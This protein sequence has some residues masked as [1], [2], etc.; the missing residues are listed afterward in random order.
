MVGGTDGADVSQM[1]GVIDAIHARVLALEQKEQDHTNVVH[2][3]IDKWSKEVNEM[4]KKLN[5]KYEEGEARGGNTQNIRKMKD[6]SGLKFKSEKRDEET[7]SSWSFEFEAHMGRMFRGAGEQFLTWA[8]EEETEIKQHHADRKAA[9]LGMKSDVNDILYDELRKTCN[10]GE[11]QLIL[12]KLKSERNGAE[13]WR[14]MTNRYDPRGPMVAQGILEKLNTIEWPKDVNEVQN[15]IGKMDVMIKEYEQITKE[16]YPE[17]AKR[18]RLV[19]ILPGDYKKHVRVNAQSFKTYDKVRDFVLEQVGVSREEAARAENLKTTKKKEKDN[20]ANT[21]E[22]MKTMQQEFL[23]AM[24]NHQWPSGE[25]QDDGYRADEP[26]EPPGFEDLNAVYG[27]KGQGKGKGGSYGGK[28]PWGGG[29]KG[30]SKGFGGKD[31]AYGYKGGGKGWGGGGKGDWSGGGGKGQGGPKGGEFQGECHYCGKFGH[32]LNQCPKKTADMARMRAGRANALDES[33]DDDEEEVAILCEECN[34]F[35]ANIV[36]EK[37]GEVNAMD[38]QE[39]DGWEKHTVMVDSGSTSSFL[40]KDTLPQVEVKPPSE[41]D[42]KR[43][44]STADGASVKMTG[45]SKVNFYTNQGKGKAHK[46]NRS[47]KI[48]KNLSSVSEYADAGQL[49]IF[50]KKGGGIIKDPDERIARWLMASNPSATPFRRDKG[51][52]TYSL[53]MW[54]QKA[55]ADKVISRK[56]AVSFAS[57]KKEKEEEIGDEN[58][59]MEVD[60]VTEEEWQ[61]YL[62]RSQKQRRNKANAVFTGPR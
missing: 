8:A 11:P 56:K 19:A 17:V 40:K 47:D 31:T 14:L 57:S 20:E 48:A 2:S 42:A 53:D 41:K 45:T 12:R 50:S 43:R 49:V 3:N 26:N 7:F 38:E 23:N 25:H 15:M 37:I 10:D 35:E 18:G 24:W 60:V 36:E 58:E 13:A 22:Q 21:L 46:F 39:Y 52:G 9:E 59:D 33:E 30:K 55:A 4:I 28:G 6:P 54:V 5:D 1:Q 51:K 16:E 61:E 27:N 34:Q 32:R 62:T 44:W 29:G